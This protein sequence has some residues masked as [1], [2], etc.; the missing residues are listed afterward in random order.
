MGTTD[1]VVVGAGVIG[2]TSAVALAEEG[3]KVACWTA[4]PASRTT[5]SVAGAMWAG[6]PLAVPGDRLTGWTERSLPVF[7]ELA[8]RSEGGV[9]I[10]AGV[11]ASRELAEPPPAQMFPG[12]ELHRAER[13]PAGYRSAFELEVPLIDM[14]RYLGYLEARLR[15]A[16]AEVALHPVA[17]LEQAAAAAPLVVNCTGM[18]RASSRRMTR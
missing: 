3:M 2:L 4:A 9:H 17:A 6:S 13:V 1:A 5:S 14:S 16:G 11:V 18:G 8:R 7:R 10:A 15:S 12:V